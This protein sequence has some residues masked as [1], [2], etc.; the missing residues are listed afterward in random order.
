MGVLS[1]ALPVAG[2]PSSGQT[3]RAPGNHAGDAFKSATPGTLRGTLIQPIKPIESM[4]ERTPEQDAVQEAAARLVRQCIA[5]D[6][7]AWQ[8]LVLSHHRRIYAICYRFTGSATDAEDLTQ[9]V[10]LKLYKNLASFD[11]QKGSF[12]TWITTLT[13]NLLVD[14]F[15]R[16]RME[17]ASDSLD[18]TFD[19]EED[20]PTMADR[21]ADTRESQE[22]HM[23]S[24][25]LKVRIQEALQ[26]L[27]PELREA[28]I[29]RD[30]E[31][32]DYKEIAQVLRIPEGTVK[33]RISRGR[34]ELARL[35]Q[36]IEKQQMM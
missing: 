20:G 35:L 24:L 21:L 34:G 16:S 27:S 12:Q 8:Q 26:Q 7:Q 11:L 14:H 22:Q 13:R 30:L 6:G 1:I 18:A 19:G 36:R 32:M 17:R 23:A 25:E 2:R 9:D 10:F 33:S 28:V 15:R 5:G 4:L 31:D 29:L 3:R